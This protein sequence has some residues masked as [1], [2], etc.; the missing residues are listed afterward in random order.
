MND[1]AAAVA[2]YAALFE[3]DR[4][5]I[6][7][8]RELHDKSPNATTR[9]DLVQAYGH[10]GWHAL[11]G[12]RNKESLQHS[13]TALE[14]DSSRTWVKVNLGHAYLFLGR[15]GEARKIYIEV[16]DVNRTDDGKRKYAHEIRDDFALFRK[17]GIGV[18]A[19]DAVAKDIGI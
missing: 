11:L 16:K 1:A 7:V 15:A 12:G 9:D 5:W 18:P 17:L 10:A 4:S 19:M 13:E 2:T 3:A 6:V 8:A 14:L